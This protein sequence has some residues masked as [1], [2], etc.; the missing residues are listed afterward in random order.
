[1]RGA[2]H[3]A[4]LALALAARRG[5]LA[6]GE[7]PLVLAEA[8]L[9]AVPQAPAQPGYGRLDGPLSDYLHATAVLDK[10]DFDY[11]R[12]R[13]LLVPTAELYFFLEAAS[14]K[15]ASPLTAWRPLGERGLWLAS[16][17]PEF[18]ER[19][20]G[21]TSA[22]PPR[23][24][25]A[26]LG[27]LHFTLGFRQNRLRPLLESLPLEEAVL[28]ALL[29]LTDRRELEHGLSAGRLAE[30]IWG[31]RSLSPGERGRVLRLSGHPAWPPAEERLRTAA[32]LAGDERQSAES[33]RVTGDLALATGDA[34]LA[35]RLLDRA[36][37]NPDPP[38][39]RH[40]ILLDLIKLLPARA[41]AGLLNRT[42]HAEHYA[43]GWRDPFV[44]ELAFASPHPFD[45][46][47]SLEL[48][49]RLFGPLGAPGA[50][51][52]GRWVGKL[53]P[54]ILGSPG[55]TG[56]HASAR[57][58]ALTLALL[59]RQRLDASFPPPLLP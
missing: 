30:V 29:D 49:D 53:S 33:L 48:V 1:M 57:L 56:R 8:E 18:R 5:A 39:S 59:A 42:P 12:A 13:R 44:L 21:L 19:A 34:P 58:D 3:G 28:A 50:T 45:E 26:R 15:P 31:K 41:F 25:E 32:R 40:P 27:W 36:V 4:E 16:Q 55:G 46:P 20:A 11:L 23:A 47:T 52:L 10:P 24:A 22:Q 2:L 7:L 51:R 37:D 43:R 38:L 17:H 9:P 54:A 35:E 14:A 6:C